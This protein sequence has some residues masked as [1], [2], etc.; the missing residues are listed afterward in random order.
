MMKNKALS[1]PTLILTL[2]HSAV[3]S[4]SLSFAAF[5][6]LPSLALAQTTTTTTLYVYSRMALKDLDEVNKLVTDKISESKATT[7]DKIT[8]LRE[9]M[10]AVY[11]RPN[12]DFL[13]DKVI[14]PLRTELNE[15][16]AYESTIKALI[17]EALGALKKPDK[18]K[19][20]AQV[21]YSIMLENFLAEMKP[22]SKEKFE[23]DLITM[24]R[25]ARVSLS[26]KAKTERQLGMMREGRSP[27]EIASAIL[28]GEEQAK[29]SEKKK[30][31]D[32][33]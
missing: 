17:E 9:A 28:K 2:C 4:L 25:D 22:N 11:A 16:E 7:G 18:V 10:Q 20:A 31:K 15:H 14:S 30:Q 32:E 26:K 12:D 6:S 3:A 13:I 23:R 21:T 24:V 33:F 19:T 5:V 29:G 1:L 8:P 27:S